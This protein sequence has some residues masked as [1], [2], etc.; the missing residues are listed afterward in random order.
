MP[1][2]WNV[3]QL[4]IMLKLYFYFLF[5]QTLCWKIFGNV[6]SARY[7]LWLSALLPNPIMTV[8]YNLLP[9]RLRCLW[10]RVGAGVRIEEHWQPG[11]ESVAGLCC[12]AVTLGLSQPVI[13][14]SQK[15]TTPNNYPLWCSPWS[16]AS[17]TTLEG[18]EG[19]GGVW[20]KSWSL[21]SYFLGFNMKAILVVAV[22]NFLIQCKR[23][24]GLQPSR[25]LKSSSSRLA[26]RE[27]E[28]LS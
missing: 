20:D 14:V 10:S 12:I 21:F 1:K 18:L 4:L 11:L 28:A 17:R 27:S 15:C 3:M 13:R 5:N 16:W 25:I 2:Q 24:F 26:I 19:H 9:G 23:L 7:F 8:Q 22:L 6:K